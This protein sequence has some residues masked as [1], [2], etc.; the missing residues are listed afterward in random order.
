MNAIQLKTALLSFF[1]FQRQWAYVNTESGDF[2]AD[3]LTSNKKKLV[4]IEIKVKHNDIFAEFKKPKHH[5]YRSFVEK[6]AKPINRRTQWIPNEY[7][8]AVPEHLLDTLRHQ[9]EEW[10]EYGIIVVAHNGWGIAE[11]NIIKKAKTIHNNEPTPDVLNS[12]IKRM[13]SD[14]ITLYQK[15]ELEPIM[16]NQMIRANRELMESKPK[17]RILRMRY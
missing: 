14:L 3:V 11:A 6:G 16:A 2:Y 17:K 8:F 12:M 13:G 1:R 5:Q 15:R 7:Y 9:L 4:E 10:P